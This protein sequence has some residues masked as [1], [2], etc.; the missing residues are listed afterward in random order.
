MW[1]PTWVAA[2]TGST[3]F[4]QSFA[5]NTVDTTYPVALPA[6]PASAS[7]SN[8]A[9][10]TASGN[11]SSGVLHSCPATNDP[12]GSGKLRLT[13][14]ANTQE[15]GVFAATSV[16]TSSGID[17]TFNTYQY[18][19]SNNADGIAFVLAA[20]NP[21]NPLSPANIGQSG[22]A[23]AYSANATSGLV[24]LADGYMGIGFDTY[25][26]YSNH[27]YQGTG[28]TNPPYISGTG[29][30]PGQVVV[31]GPGNGLAG[32]CA[33]NSTATTTSSPVVPLS[34][35]TRAASLVPVEVAINPTSASF[36]T[37][38][39][40]TVPAGTYKVVFTPVGRSRVTLSGTLPTVPAGLYPS[41]WL[42]SS[43][44]PQQLA[45]G[46]VA[47]T[48]GSTNF[49][50]IDAANVV[51]FTPVPQLAV[52]QTAY[53]AA[54]PALGA[55]VTYTVN[56]SVAASGA[57]ESS[58]VSVSETMPAGVTPVGAY[59]PGW[60]CGA[61]SGQV[62]TC[63]DSATPFAAG[64][65]LPALTVSGI[66]TASGVTSSTIQS[67][68]KATASSADGNPG[69]ATTAAAGTVPTGPSGVTISPATGA[70]AGGNDVTVSGTNISG[71]T[72][73]EIGTTSQQQA[74]TPV[75]L[76]PCASGSA[77]GCFTV[78]ANGS[79]DISSMPAVALGATVNVTVVTLGIAGAASYAYTSAPAAPAA[80]TATAGITSAAVSWTAPASGNS[81]ITGYIVTP[82]LNGVAQSPLSY[83]ASTTTQTLTGLT[84]GGS[85]TFT[86]TAVNAIGT[87]AASP[88][89]A[90]VTPYVLPGAP[91]IGSVSAGDS[92]ATVNWT[93]PASNGF[94]AI[95][96]YV[97]TPYIAGVAQTP[98]T[99]SSTATTQSVTGLTAGT[100]YTFKVA[101]VN[102][103]GTGP[104]SA[105]SAAVTPNAGLSL[106][107][108]PPP[109]GE[110]SIAYS[111]QLTA[112]G[113][114]GALAW[115]VSSGSL[116]PGLT[117]SSSTG[118]L[119][120]SP[121]AAG[122]YA[123]TVKITDTPGGS[124]TKAVTLVIAA[125]PSLANGSP[126]SGQ[127]GVAYSDALTVTGGT[128]PFAWA[129]SGGASRPG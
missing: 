54:S 113:G 126:P 97:V 67:G 103:A 107:F 79:L 77:P 124:A 84:A 24:G 26:N 127:A 13:N 102:A 110:V 14:A 94:S 15:G 29:T 40:I 99:F 10:L 114:T 115:S 52:T 17:A 6:L 96:G 47:S 33:I 101:A 44:I 92:A 78:N 2:A 89:S 64:A 51:S 95:T 73:I 11:S 45:F 120:G 8:T 85:Y 100:S 121:T 55:P 16:P 128:G 39:G 23:L 129:V 104:A 48:G 37:A 28:C 86:V 112:S 70:A 3:L 119:S 43:G 30:V 123:F 109:A 81:P 87:G 122:S 25:G 91:V 72:V 46:W 74:G 111:D 63:T 83:G 57:S 108:G 7:G 38:S 35:T 75:V 118:L 59:G 18:G 62:I 80:P 27:V 21:A 106:T 60:T 58:P 36:T 1:A 42:T 32:Y 53:S 117:L 66:V 50:E 90:A 71:A 49:H 12:P 19:G 93:A 22:G 69:L 125:V 41:S 116:P 61:P 31:R 5:N 56:P 68:S 9:C 76:L 34:A 20:V 88:Q 65:S 82:Y 4:A 105:M 98:Q